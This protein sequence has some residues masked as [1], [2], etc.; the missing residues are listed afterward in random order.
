M[1]DFTNPT[2]K[3][4]C[5][6][7]RP[8]Q[9]RTFCFFRKISI[10]PDDGATQRDKSQRKL[11]I[12]PLVGCERILETVVSDEAYEGRSNVSRLVDTKSLHEDLSIRT[13][14]IV[15]LISLSYTGGQSRELALSNSPTFVAVH[16]WNSNE[17]ESTKGA[18]K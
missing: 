3:N 7:L 9:R 11:R 15:K 6:L 13:K 12:A 16:P 17:T 1:V 18:V 2:D 14:N 8:R 5:D 4:S 10:S